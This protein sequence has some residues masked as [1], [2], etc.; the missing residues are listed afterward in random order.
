MLAQSVPVAQSRVFWTSAAGG[1]RFEEMVC[2]GWPD[3]KMDQPGWLVLASSLIGAEFKDD[4]EVLR[5]VQAAAAALANAHRSALE[6][7]VHYLRNAHTAPPSRPAVVFGRGDRAA[8]SD[9]L[10]VAPLSAP[11]ARHAVYLQSIAQLRRNQSS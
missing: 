9:S 3:Y 6:A 1:R 8:S 4:H 7:H 11:D 2:D 10:P 5:E